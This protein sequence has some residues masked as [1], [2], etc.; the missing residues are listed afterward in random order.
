MPIVKLN[1]KFS[2]GQSVWIKTDFEQIERMVVAIRLIGIEM[3]PLY[4]IA[5]GEN[6]SEHYEFEL[7]EERDIVK[8][9]T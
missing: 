8:A 1:L 9:T 4:L 3:I 2:I 5:F 7:T 6:A